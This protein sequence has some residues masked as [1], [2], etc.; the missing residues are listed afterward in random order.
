MAKAIKRIEFVITEDDEAKTYKVSRKFDGI[1]IF[2]A[3]GF[4]GM[5]TDR[6]REQIFQ[7]WEQERKESQL[8]GNQ[9]QQS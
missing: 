8:D 3:I 9:D 1:H 6:L 7:N 5:E 4:L 2:E